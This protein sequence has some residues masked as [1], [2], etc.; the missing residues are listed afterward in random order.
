[1][2]FIEDDYTSCISNVSCAIKIHFSDK[3]YYWHM[4]AIYNTYVVIMFFQAVSCVLT[5]AEALVSL[6]PSSAALLTRV[7]LT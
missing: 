1:M 2:Q 4:S 5:L 3:E 6:T 7:A